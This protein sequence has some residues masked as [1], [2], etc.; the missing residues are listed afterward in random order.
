VT[1]IS[2]QKP[3]DAADLVLPGS[4]QAIQ[5]TALYARTNGYVRRWNVDIG[6]KVEAGQLLAEIETPEVDQELNQAR[7]NVTQAIANADLARATLT[8]WQ[9]LVAQKVVSSQE[10]DEK[11]V[12]AGKSFTQHTQFASKAT[13]AKIHGAVFDDVNGNGVRNGDLFVSS[14]HELSSADE[15]NILRYNGTT[16]SFIDIFVP[17]HSGG[18]RFPH[19]LAF[20]PDCNI[21][22]VG[23]QQTVLRY[24]G[25]SGAFLGQFAA[26]A[27]LN[28]LGDLVFGPDGNLYVSGLYTQNIVRFDGRTGAFI[29][30]FA[31]GS[32]LDGSLGLT[33]GPDG[34]LYVL[35]Y[36]N[37]RVLR[38]NGRTGVFIDTFVSSGSGGLD[39]PFDLEFGPDGNLYLNSTATDSVLRYNG[40][41]GTF[42]DAFVPSGSGGLVGGSG[43]TF[44]PDGNLYVPNGNNDSILRYD[45]RTG[46]FIDAFVPSGS[47]SLDFPHYPIF[48]PYGEPGLQGW[49]IYLDENRNGRRDPG[50]PFL[51]RLLIRRRQLRPLVKRHVHPLILRHVSKKRHLRQHL[52]QFLRR[53][54]RRPDHSLNPPVILRQQ[55][56]PQVIQRTREQ[57]HQL[58]RRPIFLPL[59]RVQREP[60]QAFQ[61]ARQIRKLA[62][63]DLA[64]MVANRSARAAAATV[65]Q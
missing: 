33:F 6:A 3:G 45:G 20:G 16:G 65:A 32:G 2:S 31:S 57:P 21:Y 9:Q 27:L 44:G 26:S 50:E 41:T 62:E 15:G 36:N 12:F 47:G 55:Q 19:G 37:N 24:D 30:V 63:R 23:H 40:T 34:N 4:T 11:S 13:N 54:T 49:V 22:A 8:R 64:V 38:F 43:L 59:F 25:V 5:E 10:F 52:H 42:I 14:H 39:S 28:G 7:A 51:S 29:D 1:V 35:S 18:L 61:F 46:A 53:P 56:P 48:S 17:S 60:G 58:H